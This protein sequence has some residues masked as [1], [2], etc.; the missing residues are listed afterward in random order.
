MVHLSWRC[1]KETHG[2][3]FLTITAEYPISVDQKVLTHLVWTMGQVPVFE[4]EDAFS[5]TIDPIQP[6]SSIPDQAY[7]NAEIEHQLNFTNWNTS[8]ADDEQIVQFQ[9]ADVLEEHSDGAADVTRHS[10]RKHINISKGTQD[11]YENR[12]E[13]AVSNSNNVLGRESMKAAPT[14]L[15]AQAE[16]SLSSTAIDPD[17]SLDEGQV[18]KFENQDVV[19]QM[20]G[21]CLNGDSSETKELYNVNR[22]VKGHYENVKDNDVSNYHKT[23]TNRRESKPDNKSSSKLDLKRNTAEASLPFKHTMESEVLNANNPSQLDAPTLE[24]SESEEKSP[25]VFKSKESGQARSTGTA[26]FT[27]NNF[28]LTL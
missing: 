10:S 15:N 8:D 7:S 6:N 16:L 17:Y 21:N 18:V 20:K 14:Y 23:N 5:S 11:L 19:D 26:R 2:L 1:Q 27:R 12:Q 28:E 4:N 3:S 24:T 22:S 25:P 9:N 13:D